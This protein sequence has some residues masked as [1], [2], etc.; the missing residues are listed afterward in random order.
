VYE[1]MVILT[2]DRTYERLDLADSADLSRLVLNL[3][4]DYRPSARLERTIR[5]SHESMLASKVNPL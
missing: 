1:E 3:P 2:P 5:T 4:A